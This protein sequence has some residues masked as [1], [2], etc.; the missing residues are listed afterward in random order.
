M[1]AIVTS[2]RQDKAREKALVEDWPD[3]GRPGPSQVKTRTLYSGV[4]NG[5]ERNDLLR[6]NYAN[7]DEK[8]PAGWGYQNVG[9]VIEVGAD[10]TTLQVG[11]VLYMSQDHVEFCVET[12]DGL[13]ITLPPEVDPKHAALFGMASVAMH[14]CRHADL[15]MGERFLVVGAGFIGQV[16]AQIA[17]VMGARV[18]IADIDEGRLELARSIGAAEA[19]INTAGD[20]WAQQIEDGAY[21]A[22]LD[23]AGVPGMEDQLIRAAAFRGT[24]LFIAGRF[25]VEY[26]FNLGQAREI[27]IMQNS[28]FKNGDLAN[29]C[30]LVARGMVEIG[31]LIQDM[32]PAADAARIYDTLRDE[33][34]KLRGT[35][36]VW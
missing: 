21:R 5:T 20:S 28:H 8:L 15:R 36:F 30:R 4:T 25:K 14:S 16:A 10:V 3:P 34:N 27:T 22:V 26:S 24:V 23:V 18:T 35:V 9:Q 12:E 31:P 2:L 7:P 13:H 6:G 32:V 1:K 33:P 29:L 11:D 17:A 19:A